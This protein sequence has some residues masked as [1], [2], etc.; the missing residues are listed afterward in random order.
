MQRL[1]DRISAVF[2]PVVI[3]LAIGT[4]AVW[5]LT[6]GGAQAAFTAA[7][8][9]LII[10]CPCAL[11]LATPTA[12]L[13]GTGRGAQLG[14]LIK[15]PEILESTRRVDT[16]VLDKTGTVT[17]GRM[18][19]GRRRSPA[20]ASDAGRGAPLRRGRRVPVS[21]HP[22]ARA[23]AAAAAQPR[24]RRRTSTARSAPTASTSAP[25]R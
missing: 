11:G 15:G 25:T 22:I 18:E 4:L 21:E 24:P 6:G 9:V 20:R 10:A 2:V 5:L 13:V 14:I 17:E 1:A 7:V 8:A 19:R 3:V 12:L 23:V 16:V